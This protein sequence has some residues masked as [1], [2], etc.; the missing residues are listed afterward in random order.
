MKV[1]LSFE[2]K[3]VGRTLLLDY[4]REHKVSL[5]KSV[6]MVTKWIVDTSNPE[7]NRIELEITT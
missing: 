3:E 7:N 4:A 1:K 5:P 6:D 2:A